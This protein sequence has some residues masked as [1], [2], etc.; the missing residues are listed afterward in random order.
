MDTSDIGES[1]VA[2]IGAWARSTPIEVLLLS[3]LHEAEAGELIEPVQE[4]VEPEAG[5]GDVLAVG[6]S[7]HADAAAR[8]PRPIEDHGQA[9]ARA[10]S[11]REDYLRAAAARYLPDGKATIHV[12]LSEE[13]AQSI[14]A[15]AQSLGVDAIALATHGRTGLRHVVVGSVAEEVVRRSPVAVIVVGPEADPRQ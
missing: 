12:E 14:V 15:A 7:L 3:V 2:V 4:V 5:M 1:A 6:G 9:L 13:T 8:A 11:E 10:R